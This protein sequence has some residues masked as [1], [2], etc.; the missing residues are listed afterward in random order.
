M[1]FNDS[2]DVLIR[3]DPDDR[4]LAMDLASNS[5]ATIDFFS[6]EKIRGGDYRDLKTFGGGSFLSLYQNPE[7]PFGLFRG[8]TGRAALADFENPF[9]LEAG[10]PPI[11]VAMGKANAGLTAR[12][13]GTS[14]LIATGFAFYKNYQ[15]PLVGASSIV[16]IIPK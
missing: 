3:V 6:R 13:A 7:E 5:E 14:T 16:N 1:F 8:R 15:I 4:P 10:A 12:D 9:V 2:H 11:S